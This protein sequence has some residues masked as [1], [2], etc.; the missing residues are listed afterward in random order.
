VNKY[1]AFHYTNLHKIY[2]YRFYWIRDSVGDDVTKQAGA[3]FDALLFLFLS[4]FSLPY[5]KFEL[6]LYSSRKNAVF[7][8]LMLCD[9]CTKRRFGDIYCFQHQSDKIRRA[10]NNV[11]SNIV[12]SSVIL[13]RFEVSTAVT[14]K[15][16]VFRDIT[17]CGSCNNR[18]LGGN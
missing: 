14:T 2:W 6:K 16:E 12:L 13:V 9:S 1:L 3:P 18:R 8:D 5:H 17:Q 15:N 7:W 10:I 11:S 4:T